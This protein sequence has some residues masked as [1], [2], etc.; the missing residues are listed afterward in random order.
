MNVIILLVSLLSSYL[1]PS[2]QREYVP[3]AFFSMQ[4]QVVLAFEHNL[5]LNP[6]ISSFDSLA[7]AALFTSKEELLL[8]K[9]VPLSISPDPWQECLEY[10]YA[11]LTAGIC[12]GI[13]TYIH[14]NPA[15]AGTYGLILNGVS[16]NPADNTARELLGE[17][18]FI[19]DDGD[20][21][22]RGSAA[23]KIYRNPFTGEWDGIDLFD[24][25]AS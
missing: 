19:A 21:Y 20:V 2:V 7:G 12:G 25:N 9:G 17:P 5:G 15:Q 18:D 3:A 8:S 13:V 10:Q 23:L 24:A 22:I 14:V 4:P 11:D 16:L 1:S 6:Y